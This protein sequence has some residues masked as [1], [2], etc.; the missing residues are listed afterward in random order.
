MTNYEKAR[1][2]LMNTQTNLLKS[3]AKHKTETTLTTT[4]NYLNCHV[5]YF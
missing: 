5:N 4:K 3:A 2:K 1:V